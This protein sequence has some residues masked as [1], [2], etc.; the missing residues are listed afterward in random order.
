VGPVPE[1][2]LGHLSRGLGTGAQHQAC[3]QDASPGSASARLG[4]G[5][6]LSPPGCPRPPPGARPLC[7]PGGQQRC[8]GEPEAAAVP[9]GSDAAKRGAPARPPVSRPAPGRGPVTP[10]LRSPHHLPPPAAAEGSPGRA[11]HG[12][13]CRTPVARREPSQTHGTNAG[14]SKHSTHQRFPKLR[15]LQEKPTARRDAHLAAHQRRR[16]PPGSSAAPRVPS[17]APSAA[18]QAETTQ[19]RL[20]PPGFTR[21]R[22]DTAPGDGS[23]GRRVPGHTQPRVPTAG[24]PSTRSTGAGR[25]CCG[26]LLRGAEPRRC[27]PASP[28]ETPE[29]GTAL[30]MVGANRLRARSEAVGAAQLPLRTGKGR[31]VARGD[32]DAA[33]SAATRSPRAGRGGHGVARGL[34]S[35]GLQ[36]RQPRQ[37]RPR[38]PAHTGCSCPASP[39]KRER[40]DGGVTA[41]L[42][43]SRLRADSRF[44]QKELLRCSKGQRR[45]DPG[46][47]TPRAARAG[48]PM[49]M[50]ARSPASPA[51]AR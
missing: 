13:R 15:S 16:S 45:R 20:P 18:L 35:T 41:G 46:R 43:P 40:G 42:V 3:R 6:G 17:P 12:H 37:Q 11:G 2:R 36:P 31:G 9:T 19:E 29:L 21:R 26:G 4:S 44:R 30:A 10:I 25:R 8:Q 22:W 24:A 5:Q 49:P 48:V 50:A 38:P 1:H 32:D 27:H 28:G 33:A 51:A 14:K 7:K 23:G 47:E 39:R 34:T